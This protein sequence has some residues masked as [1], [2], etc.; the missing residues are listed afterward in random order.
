[1]C[2]CIPDGTTTRMFG[3]S[4]PDTIDRTACTLALDTIDRGIGIPH[5]IIRTTARITRF[6][7]IGAF[8]VGQPPFARRPFR[9]PPAAGSLL[10]PVTDQHELAPSAV[11]V[12][13]RRE[14]VR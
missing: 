9:V 13:R 3:G 4:C 2:S 14:R 8:R 7:C 12:E 6:R 5:T 11:W 10:V 1:M